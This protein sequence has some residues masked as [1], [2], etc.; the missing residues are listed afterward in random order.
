MTNTNE[1]FHCKYCLVCQ[2]LLLIIYNLL[3]TLLIRKV[4]PINDLN[5]VL[6]NVVKISN[7]QIIMHALYLY[8][9]CSKN[10]ILQ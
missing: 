4:V 10:L 5:F 1:Y 6:A 2:T 3:S 9:F 8:N 7:I